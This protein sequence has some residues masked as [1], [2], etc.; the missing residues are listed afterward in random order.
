MIGIPPQNPAKKDPFDALSYFTAKLVFLF[1]YNK[2]KSK[3]LLSDGLS[4]DF[5]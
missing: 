1:R 3:F 5:Y 2:F 4:K